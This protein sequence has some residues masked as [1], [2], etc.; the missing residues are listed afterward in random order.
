VEAYL[1]HVYAE[2]SIRLSVSLCVKLSKLISM[3]LCVFVDTAEV[4]NYWRP[5]PEKD[6]QKVKNSD[7]DIAPTDTERP[8]IARERQ[9]RV[10]P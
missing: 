9:R 6:F 2:L 3:K 4:I 8:N 5:P 10:K 1:Q 7:T